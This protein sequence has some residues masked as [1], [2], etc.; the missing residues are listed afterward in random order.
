MNKHLKLSSFILK[1]IAL[2]T[3]T[4]D[5][6]GIF[7]M[8]TFMQNEKLYSLGYLFRIIG[9]LAFPLFTLFL[10]EGLIH[11]NNVKKYL[12]RLFYMLV[13]ILFVQVIIYYFY[14]KDIGFNPFIDLLINGLFIYFVTKKDKKKYIAILPL[15]F[16]LFSTIVTSIELLKPSYN[17]SW[18][19]L[20]LK[21]GYS[22]FGFL[23]TIAF[24]Y[25]YHFAK[26]IILS[27]ELEDENISIKKLNDVPNYRFLVNLI[28]A[29]SLFI[30]NVFIWFLASLHKSLDIYY[31]SIQT[32]SLLAGLLI[33]FYH[34]RQ[35]YHAKWFKI[36]TYLYF[37]I[38]IALITLIF[39]ILF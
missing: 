17:F 35:G 18:F 14:T 21:M 22:L 1:I 7:I 5:H 29:I 30:L 16:V 9:R 38:H 24:Y 27:K 20:Y 36:F 25:S 12:L 15:L 26:K 28:M 33:I 3:M 31:A 4:L 34:G 8:Q 13:G 19:P 11:S 37:P 6:V 39:V 2:L 32:W 10:V 23:L